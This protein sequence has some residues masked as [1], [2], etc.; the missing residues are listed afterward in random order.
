LGE[1]RGRNDAL[2]TYMWKEKARREEKRKKVKKVERDEDKET[3][4]KLVSKRFW[5]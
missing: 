2:S 3:L 1:R 5:R 4:K